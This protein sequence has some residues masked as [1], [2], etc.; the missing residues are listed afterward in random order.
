MSFPHI[1]K[2]KR[3]EGL[4]K[5]RYYKSQRAQIKQSIKK[6]LVG[7]NAFFIKDNCYND[8]IANMKLIDMIKSI[9]GIGDIKAR[10]IMKTLYIS[11]RKTIKGLSKK[12][13]ENFKKYFK[14]N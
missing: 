3:D 14:I 1:S 4:K 8:I 11:G 5:A 12:Q 2:E 6:G 10:K 13:K 7:F 9:P